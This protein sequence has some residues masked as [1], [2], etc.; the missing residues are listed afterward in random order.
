VQTLR[1]RNATKVDCWREIKGRLPAQPTAQ[2]AA[3]LAVKGS[4]VPSTFCDR[5]MESVASGRVQAAR[6]R[7]IDFER[8]MGLSHAAGGL[9]ALIA[10]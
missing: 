10:A 4:R 1:D 2:L 9:P 6:R 3:T 8:R 7:S 5:L